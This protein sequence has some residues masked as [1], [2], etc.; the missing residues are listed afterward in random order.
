MLKKESNISDA[1][2]IGLYLDNLHL[3]KK[4]SAKARGHYIFKN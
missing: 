1:I 3:K 2:K 4:Q